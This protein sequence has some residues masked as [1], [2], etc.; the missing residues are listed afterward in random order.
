M[1]LADYA[2]ATIADFIDRKVS[3]A[4]APIAAYLAEHAFMA[5]VVLAAQDTVVND[6]RSKAAVC[7]FQRDYGLQV[8]GIP[9]P[10]TQRRLVEICGY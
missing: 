3:T 4:E 5:Q 9:G 10:I 7:A 1:G 2:P 6:H 8:D